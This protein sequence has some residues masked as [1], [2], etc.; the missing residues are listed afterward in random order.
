MPS[1]PVASDSQGASAT[2]VRGAIAAL[3]QLILGLAPDDPG[4]PGLAVR[5]HNVMGV[6]LR[7]G[8]ATGLSSSDA[9][10]DLPD[11]HTP[12]VPHYCTKTSCT[13]AA[14][15]RWATRWAGCSSWTPCS[16]ATSPCPGQL[17][18]TFTAGRKLRRATLTLPLEQ[19]DRALTGHRVSW[20]QEWISNGRDQAY[21]ARTDHRANTERM[22]SR[23]HLQG[24]WYDFLLPSM[25]ADHARLLAAGR[26]VRLL[27]GPWGHGR[28]LYTREGM[29]DALAALDAAMNGDAAPT[30]GRLS[31]VPCELVPSTP[32]RRR[33][34]CPRA[35]SSSAA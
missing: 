4:L 29:Q 18:A 24:G 13:R 9:R 11:E 8:H 15:S 17:L 20:F 19:A 23:V 34:P 30:R 2:H 10:A 6:M 14:R 16:V 27:V 35:H 7:I 5:L 33:W 22:P 12:A 1:E 25:L 32:A 26:G 3:E 31:A 28:G 21:W